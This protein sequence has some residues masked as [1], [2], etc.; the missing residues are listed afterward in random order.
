M[1]S[2][3]YLNVR[4]TRRTKILSLKNIRFFKNKRELHHHN[5][6]LSEAD[7]V[8]IT[9]EYQKKD[10]KNDTIT[11]HK[12][13]DTLLC[14]V[15]IWAKIVKRIVNYPNTNPNTQVNTYF[16]NGKHYLITGSM[17]LKQLRR[18]TSALGKDTLGFSADEIGL[19]SARSGAAMAMYLAKVPVFTI[20][21][22]GRW[23]SDAFLLYI[24]KQV[25]DFSKDISSKMIMNEH[26]FTIPDTSKEDPRISNHLQNHS[27]RKNSGIIPKEAFRPLISLFH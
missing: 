20:M 27:S 9:F 26:F 22:I 4:G 3:E 14:P 6:K 12:S 7:T 19:H 11:Q 5:P 15:K 13:T 2:C 23:S 24:R 8:S 17:L 25:Q 21:L 10:T 18:A 16:D 1:R